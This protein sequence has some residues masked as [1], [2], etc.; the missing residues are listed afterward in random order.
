MM[1][2][3]VKVGGVVQGRRSK[4]GCQLDDKDAARFHAESAL[5][6]AYCDG[7]DYK[8]K[9]AYEEAERLLKQLGG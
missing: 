8:Y 3:C 7:G 4:V 9:V 5:R 2:V 1:G 6:L